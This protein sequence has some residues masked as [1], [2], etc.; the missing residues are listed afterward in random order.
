MPRGAW[1]RRVPSGAVLSGIAKAMRTT[2]HCGGTSWSGNGA[3]FALN[4]DPVQYPM[5][6]WPLAWP[7]DGA[8]ATTGAVGSAAL[9]EL[10]SGHGWAGPVSAWGSGKL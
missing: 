5:S 6:W 2:S 10:R 4:L 3:A 8:G 7:L 9:A 1:K